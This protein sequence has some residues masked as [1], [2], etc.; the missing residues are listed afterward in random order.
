[1]NSG[2]AATAGASELQR[3]RDREKA[4]YLWIRV[5]SVA[6]IVFVAVT[7]FQAR[8]A[9]GGHGQ[10]LGVALMLVVFSAAPRSPRCG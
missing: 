9:P 8:P 7:S 4:T 1:V 6:A 2:A 10:A 3:A 5:L